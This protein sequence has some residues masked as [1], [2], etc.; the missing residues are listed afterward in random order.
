MTAPLARMNRHRPRPT[1]TITWGSSKS[2]KVL[3]QEAGDAQRG[4]LSGWNR[5]KGRPGVWTWITKNGVSRSRGTRLLGDGGTGGHLPPELFVRGPAGDGRLGG[6]LSGLFGGRGRGCCDRGGGLY[7][8]GGTG[9]G[10]R[11]LAGRGEEDQPE[12]RQNNGKDEDLPQSQPTFRCL[13]RMGAASRAAPISW[14]EPSWDG[15]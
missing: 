4:R 15:H 14:S 7:W 10:G 11:L 12:D 3:P 6:G 13:G 1:S 9:R 8:S 5:L 2:G